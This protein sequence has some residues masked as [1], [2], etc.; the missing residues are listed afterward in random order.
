MNMENSANTSPSQVCRRMIV[1]FLLLK[2]FIKNI[3]CLIFCCYFSGR[4]TLQT[5]DPL[6][7]QSYEVIYSPGEVGE[8]SHEFKVNVLNN[9][10]ENTVFKC[11]Y[12]TIASGKVSNLRVTV[13]SDAKILQNNAQSPQITESPH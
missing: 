12:S 4:H 5:L 11:R 10:F 1:F 2:E 13:V 8:H 7:T 3:I 6:Q 9:S